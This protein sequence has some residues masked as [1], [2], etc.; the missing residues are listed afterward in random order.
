MK[1][2][3]R[4]ALTVALAAASAGAPAAWVEI[5]KFDDGMRVF[6]DRA[7]ARRSGATAQ[8]THLVRWGEAQVDEGLPPYRSTIVRSAYDCAGKREKYLASTS[9]AGPM[10]DGAEVLAD[11][12]E[13]DAWYSISASSMEEKLWTLA[14]AAK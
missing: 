3:T 11:E 7:T 5:H 4:L 2:L 10:G 12:D 6:V 1:T 14:C 13:A 8:A 9:Y